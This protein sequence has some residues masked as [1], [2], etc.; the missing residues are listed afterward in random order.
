MNGKEAPQTTTGP[1]SEAKTVQEGYADVT[2]RI[3][4]DHGHEFGPLTP[5]GEAKI[6][7]KLYFHIMILV[8]V[9]NITLF[10]SIPP[11]R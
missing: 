10:V 1:H 9:I 11:L 7:W 5:A 6:R 3:I 2:L 8:S 4:E